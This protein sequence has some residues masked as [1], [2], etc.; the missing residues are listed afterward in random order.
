MIDLTSI[1]IK[2]LNIVKTEGPVLPV[3]I[4][5]KLDQDTIFAG[6]LLSELV[7]NKKILVS[8]AK[9]G[10]SPLYY[11]NGQE[12]KLDLLY[13][14]LPSKEREAY[15]LLRKNQVVQDK[16]CDPAIR[17][18]LRSIKDFSFPFEVNN[19]LYWRWYLTSE[20]E[21]RNLIG[22]VP[23]IKVNIKPEIK[24]EPKIKEFKDDTKDEFFEVVNDYLKNI[25][26]LELKVVRKKR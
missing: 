25:K 16:V 24:V 8:S 22:K 20:D 23:E 5:R 3:Q 6:A 12:S 1:R 17:V 4:S 26:V 2:I 14:H 11:I 18:A 21:A 15:E 19:E 9:V 13:D 7:T 10:G